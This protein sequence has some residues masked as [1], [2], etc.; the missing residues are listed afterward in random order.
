MSLTTRS[1]MAASSKTSIPTTRR[2]FA[3]ALIDLALAFVV[4]RTASLYV[5]SG[6]LADFVVFSAMRAALHVGFGQSVGK[7]IVGIRLE[8]LQEVGR[9]MWLRQCVLREVP[10]SAIPLVVLAMQG[11]LAS[12][13]SPDALGS[14]LLAMGALGAIQAVVFAWVVN[15]ISEDPNGRGLHDRLA[16]TRVVFA[17]RST[18]A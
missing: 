13:D 12:T 4:V 7:F 9:S 14:T 10:F 16:D 15:S 6:V 1:L 18:T 5:F 3:A 17:R 11:L 8:G 2:R